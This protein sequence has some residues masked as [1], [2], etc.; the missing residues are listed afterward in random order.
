MLWLL[1]NYYFIEKQDSK[2]DIVKLISCSN[3][4]KIFILLKKAIVVYIQVF[5]IKIKKLNL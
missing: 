5:I 3:F 1:L 2:I 4:D